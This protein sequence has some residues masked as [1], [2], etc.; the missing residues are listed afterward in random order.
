VPTFVEI[1]SAERFDTY[2]TWANADEALAIRL[3]TFNVQ[4][5]TA[6]Y[7]PMHML[8]VALRNMSDKALTAAF[9]DWLND[10]AV[11]TT[12]YQQDC[13]TKAKATLARERKTGT[14][15]QLVAELNLGFWSSLFGRDSTHLWS[16]LRPI[17]Q[18]RGI[19][20]NTIAGQLRELR[21]LRN[22]IAHYEPILA[23]P[24]AQRYA[25]ITTL[26]G[27]F[28][29]SAAG[30]IAQTSNWPSVYPSVPILVSDAG[31]LRISSTVIPYI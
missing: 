26:V 17:F 19:Q 10:P 28:S 2:R 24:L 11:L 30:W 25:S 22:R 5:S 9:G 14:H 1:L 4:L 12:W 23:L 8:E 13:V 21:I 29:P 15:S 18:A 7:G 16:T 31:V 20:R 6:L 27:W 3:Y